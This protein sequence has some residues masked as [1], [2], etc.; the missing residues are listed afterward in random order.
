MS[1]HFT[2][3]IAVISSAYDYNLLALGAEWD[4][5]QV[6][7]FQIIIYVTRVVKNLKEFTH[8]GLIFA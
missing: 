2:P 8:A 7:N 1:A 5:I 6:L 3:L 4:L